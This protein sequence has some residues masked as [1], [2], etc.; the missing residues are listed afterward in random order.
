[1]YR[2]RVVASSFVLDGKNEGEVGEDEEDN[3][4]TERKAS[5]HQTLHHF[6]SLFR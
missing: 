1:M 6:A 2:C 3:E 5:Y 4:T